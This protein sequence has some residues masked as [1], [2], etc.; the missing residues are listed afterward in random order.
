MDIIKYVT[1]KIFECKKK[2]GD[3]LLAGPEN[4]QNLFSTKYLLLADGH[5]LRI[6]HVWTCAIIFPHT[7]SKLTVK[8]A[9]LIAFP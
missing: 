6:M 1:Y 8:F 5:I 3:K 4:K 9:K 7:F 2:K